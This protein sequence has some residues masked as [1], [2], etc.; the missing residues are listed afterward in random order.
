MKK[1][2]SSL[3]VFTLVLTL[4]VPAF[5]FAA[6]QGKYTDVQDTKLAN[7]VERL[8]VLGV[9]N[10]YPD[11]TF[12]PDQPITR[13]EFSKIV[14][15]VLGLSDAAKM[16]VANTKFTDVKADNWASGYINVGVDQ[17]LFK[18]YTDGTFKPDRN[19]SQAEV[20]A[21]LIR[22]LGY[23]PTVT[24]SW[25]ANYVVKAYDLSLTKGVTVSATSAA[26]RGQVAL[27]TDNALDIYKWGLVQTNNKG[28]LV[29]GQTNKTLL[30]DNLGVTVIPSRDVSEGVILTQVPDLFNA[31]SGKIIAEDPN[32]L[33]S[34][35]N[36]VVYSLNLDSNFKVDISKL[37]HSVKLYVN[38]STG[39][40]FYAQDVTTSDQVI[41]GKVTD[42]GTGTIEVDG[43]EYKLGDPYYAFLN[44][45]SINNL[46]SNLNVSG[47][48]QEGSSVTLI[49]NG[50]GKVQAVVGEDYGAPEV[51]SEVDTKNNKLILTD[52]PTINIDDFDK[53]TIIRNGEA[54]KFTDLQKDDV[55]QYYTSAD[56]KELVLYATSNPVTGTFERFV[57]T[58]DGYGK[59]SIYVD[60]K[61]YLLNKNTPI[62]V[63]NG[64]DLL[65][66]ELGNFVDKNVTL[67]LD[68]D[69]KVA[70]IKTNSGTTTSTNYAVI[71]G[72]QKYDL[73]N[74]TVVEIS[75]RDGKEKVLDLAKKLTVEDKTVT[76]T[77]TVSVTNSYNQDLSDI[78]SKLS[79]GD[80]ITYSLDDNGNISKIQLLADNF[81]FSAL[82]INKKAST[83]NSIIVDDN[84]VILGLAAPGDYVAATR[85]QLLNA[86]GNYSGYIYSSGG[87]A[88]VILVNSQI[89]SNSSYA[90]V[91]SRYK[92][93]DIYLSLLDS[94]GATKNYKG[95]V[96]DDV[97][98]GKN[99]IG[100]DV[101]EYTTDGTDF[102]SVHELN[103]LGN[104]YGTDTNNNVLSATPYVVSKNGNVLT[105]RFYDENNLKVEFTVV[106][107]E[108]TV[109]YDATGDDVVLSKIGDLAKGQ[110]LKIYS[111]AYKDTNYASKAT[112]SAD[113]ATF[114]ADVIVITE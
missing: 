4:L 83:V 100:G 40:V 8:S 15:A 41:T 59:Q 23:D 28:E 52:S 64:D 104:K 24:G 48:D 92:S 109:V 95:S 60:G 9:L 53:V 74:A 63:D 13:A 88:K 50:N 12:R 73:Y 111:T 102:V 91:L 78:Y 19:V 2:I 76:P 106:V 11:G 25:P 69:G 17:N 61:K 29:Y 10:G 5:A 30:T 37:G 82:N 77:T 81:T 3:L 35:G 47:D 103:Y 70:G 18:G 34:N 67:F 90:Y 112:L 44:R 20:L 85:D 110:T 79:A 72:S 84:T 33:D 21:V 114:V 65:V 45:D 55:V 39:K 89:A 6:D 99:V 97:Y 108:D 75:D 49:L 86:S 16:S 46:A 36:P 38:S 68:K 71:L 107:T 105:V 56:D 94:S 31:A 27:L 51:V 62:D 14:V 7:A 43:T 98:Q 96:L 101:V 32:N 66:D 54:A 113:G 58:G 26:T 93:S 1:K 87:Y 22:A 57:T 80:L 42:I